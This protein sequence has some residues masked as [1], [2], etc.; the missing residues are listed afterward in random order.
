M[1][2]LIYN[3]AKKGFVDG[4]IDWDGDTIKVMLVG[5]TYTPDKDHNFV[6]EVVSTE[7]S[8]TGYERKSLENKTVVQ[9]DV[10]DVAKVDADDI[11]WESIQAGTAKGMVVYKQGS[12]DTDSILIAYIDEGGFPVVSNGGDLIMEF[13]SNG[14]IQLA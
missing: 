10:N 2:N 14:I 5:E 9:D 3:K 7:L 8:G 6:S 1:S 13:H 12:S 11:T 4:T